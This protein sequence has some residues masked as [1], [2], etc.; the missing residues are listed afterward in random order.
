MNPKQK[1]LLMSAID[2]MKWVGEMTALMRRIGDL[3]DH[4]NIA[5][6]DKLEAIE[7]GKRIATLFKK[8]QE[9]ADAQPTADDL[10]EQVIASHD[11][12]REEVEKANA[13]LDRLLKDAE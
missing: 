5:S 6:A 4:P 3:D 8:S 11:R 1:R 12:L 2:V 7:I 9:L 13:F 10:I